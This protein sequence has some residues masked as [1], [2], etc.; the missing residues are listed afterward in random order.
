MTFQIRDREKAVQAMI[1]D[2]AIVERIE[3]FSVIITPIPG[4]FPV[5]V[6]D[7]TAVVSII[8]DDGELM[9]YPLHDGRCKFI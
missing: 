2:D 7:S 6:Q 8:D 9:H 1:L 3:Q 5:A 4:L